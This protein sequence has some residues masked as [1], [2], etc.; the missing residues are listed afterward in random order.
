[1]GGCREGAAWLVILPRV[2]VGDGEREGM[3][4]AV[5]ELGG[6]VWM[7]GIWGPFPLLSWSWPCIYTELS[8]PYLTFL[9]PQVLVL[10]VLF[11]L[12]CPSAFVCPFNYC[13]RYS[14][15]PPELLR[16][17]WSSF[18]YPAPCDFAAN[19]PY[20]PLLQKT[21]VPLRKSQKCLEVYTDFLTPAPG[22]LT[23]WATDAG[24]ERPVPLPPIWIIH[25]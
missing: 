14:D 8:S 9:L 4:V 13:G 5:G 1:M 12:H 22:A 25:S 15:A 24:Y 19:K 7:P 17:L 10:Y 23:Q 3:L 6:K 21:G 16:F 18:V 2:C 20:L 11:C